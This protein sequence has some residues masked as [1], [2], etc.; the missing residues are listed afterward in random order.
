MASTGLVQLFKVEAE[1][2]NMAQLGYPIYLLT[3]LGSWKIL[4]V[5]AVL[6][7]G[8]PLLREWAY[9]GFSL[10]CRGPH[11]PVSHPAVR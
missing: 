5:A 7:P 1:V 11:F 9:A 2:N 6:V 4:G 10:P 3:L 8:F